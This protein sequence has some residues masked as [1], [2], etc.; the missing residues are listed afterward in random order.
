MSTIVLPFARF[1]RSAVRCYLQHSPVMKGKALL[2]DS[3]RALIR[4]Y[5]DLFP[6]CEVRNRTG[7]VLQ[8]RFSESHERD[9]Y[10]WGM[11]TP[12]IEY[13]L[14]RLLRNGDVFIDVGANVGYFSMFAS[15]LVGPDGQVL[16]FEPSPTSADIFRRNAARN[17]CINV[18]IHQVAV[19]DEAGE[20][21]LTEPMVG[22]DLATMRILSHHELSRAVTH[23]V[24]T[25]ALDDVL[26]PMLAKRVR[27]VKIDVEG[28]E[29]LVLRGMKKLLATS[30]SL[31]VVCEVTDSYLRQMNT[32][33]PELLEFVCS[34][35]YEA[36][37]I[38]HPE[39]C[40][41]GDYQFA[42]TKRP[43]LLRK[44]TGPPEDPR[45]LQYDALFMRSASAESLFHP[46]LHE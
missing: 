25:V 8:S 18:E 14:R 26:E 21:D 11:W 2:W 9:V 41:L 15:Q 22:C 20:R 4:A 12:P 45:I 35:G 37:R 16:G 27:L 32:S 33:A 23:H 10:F 38:T 7:L 36:F 6:P 3:M 39:N 24:K 42:Q 46:L 31:C 44:L 34:L 29:M 28:A 30:Q 5:P 43:Y 1:A 17:G 13:L 40:Q 19:S